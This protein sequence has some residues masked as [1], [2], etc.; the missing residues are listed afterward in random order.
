MAICLPGRASSVN[1][2]ET[3][4]IRSAPLV[5]TTKLMIIRI[6][7]TTRP[8]TKLPPMTTLPNDSITLPAAWVP[9]LPLS[10]TTRVEATFNVRRMSVVARM[11][12]GKTEKSSGRL[13]DRL[14][15]ITTIEST[16]LNVKSVS[17]SS[18][19]NGSITIARMAKTRSGVRNL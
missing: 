14:T 9:S 19:G 11:T 10:S 18:G 1:R 8:T 16:M 6:T 17:S 4:E 15:R 7:N 5:T 3:S 12:V 13:T 2:A